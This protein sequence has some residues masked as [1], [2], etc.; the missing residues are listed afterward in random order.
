M[1]GS[2]YRITGILLAG[3]RSNRMGM[4]KGKIQIG[5]Q[6]L[7]QYPLK[8][9]ER[10]CDE[11]FISTSKGFK[12]TEKYALISDEVPGIGPM[13]GIYTCLQKSSNDLNIVLSYDMPLINE[14]LFRKLIIEGTDAD[15]TLPVLQ[16]KLPEPL[17]GIYRKCVAE[18]FQELIE[19]DKFAVHQVF[20]LVRTKLVFI[21]DS[22][23]FYRP[24]I[25]LN[26]NQES[27]LSKLPPGFGEG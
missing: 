21:D 8:V 25:F 10:I 26:I 9:L 2:Q 4:E 5:N 13:G 20:P 11:I 19:E 23:P 7:Y 6:F 27:D 17:C 22:M 18:K 12:P 15:I 3:G 16:K 14:G 24:D 1:K